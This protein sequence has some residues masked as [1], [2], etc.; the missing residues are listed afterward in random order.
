[1]ARSHEYRSHVWLRVSFTTYLLAVHLNV[2]DVVLE[3]RGHVDLWELVLTEDDEQA[4]LSTSA[5]TD[6][7]QLL[8][9]GRH[10]PNRIER[11][12]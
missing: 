1:M 5:V 2:S 7:H 8:P 12:S 11:F 10:L 6:D 3:H 4:G 9:D